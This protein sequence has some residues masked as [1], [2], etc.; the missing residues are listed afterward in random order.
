[1]GG[2]VGYSYLWDNGE[3]IAQAT[4]LTAGLHSVTVTDNLGYKT[5]CEV[6]IEQPQAALSAT[7][8]I[9]NNNNCVGCANGSIVQTVI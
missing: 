2:N 1:S 4:A 3:T 7:A 9:I 8:A 5:T 6:T